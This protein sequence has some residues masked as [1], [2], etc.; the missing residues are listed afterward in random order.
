MHKAGNSAI[1]D[2]CRQVQALGRV[3][4]QYLEW[5]F[6][7]SAPNDDVTV[8]RCSGQWKKPSETPHFCCLLS[9]YLPSIALLNQFPQRSHLA[10]LRHLLMVR[11]LFQTEPPKWTQ[12][13]RENRSIHLWLL[14]QLVPAFLPWI[15]CCCLV[16]K[17]CPNLWDPMDYSPLGSSVHGILQARILEWAAIPFPGELPD[18]GI[19]PA[20]PALAGGFFTTEPPGKPLHPLTHLEKFSPAWKEMYMDLGESE[21]IIYRGWLCAIL[22][23][24]YPQAC[25]IWVFAA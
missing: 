14:W 7:D 25:W 24:C 22:S 18:P 16:A 5:I 9:A 10:S 13:L 3:L 21:G 19:R 11:F 23:L 8:K 6:E 1:C 17:S 2:C 20:S 4:C 12:S 15:S